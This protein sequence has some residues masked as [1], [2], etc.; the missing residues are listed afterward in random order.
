MP[1]LIAIDWGTSSF[2]AYLLNDSGEIFSSIHSDCGILHLKKEQFAH[3]LADQIEQLEGNKENAPI[4]I[5][6][7]ITSKSGW[8]ET[9]YVEC[10]ASCS[11]LADHLV[12][13]KDDKLGPLWFVPGLNQFTPQPDV[14]RGEETQ[15]AGLD[16]T[17][18]HIAI[19]P[20]THSKWVRLQDDTVEFFSTYMTGDL[21]NAL[22]K[23]TILKAAA[24]SIWSQRRFTEGLE[25]ARKYLTQQKSILSTL[26]QT[27]SQEILGL[28]PANE[29]KGFLSGLL[30]GTEICDAIHL[31][32]N[33]DKPYVLIGDEKLVSLYAQALEYYGKSCDVPESNLAVTGLFTIAK[34]KK[35]I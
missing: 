33:S 16:R 22:L 2:R 35:L 27:R 13:H 19:L 5:S 9:P 11:Q 31:G 1:N 26:F 7:M 6:G 4:I 15:M 30:I 8:I 17:G 23:E 18:A 10:P 34:A 20:G 24:E 3:I 25:G 12:L 14:I 32:Y 28:V 29:G 21:Y